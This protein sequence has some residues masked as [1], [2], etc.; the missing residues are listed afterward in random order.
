MKQRKYIVI[1]TEDKREVAEFTKINLEEEAHNNINFN[2]ENTE[3]VLTKSIWVPKK[4]LVNSKKAQYHPGRGV[5]GIMTNNMDD[6]RDDEKNIAK[7]ITEIRNKNCRHEG[8]TTNRKIIIIKIR[9]VTVE[10]S[11]KACKRDRLR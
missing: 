2:P 11:R 4:T 5:K 10:D 7:K 3:E 9:N 6:G 1:E 8:I